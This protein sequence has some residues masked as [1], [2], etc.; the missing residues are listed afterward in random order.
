MTDINQLIEADEENSKQ[1]QK[2]FNQFDPLLIT[3]FD[4]ASN[5]FNT[6]FRSFSHGARDDDTQGSISELAKKGGLTES[7]FKEVLDGNKP[8]KLAD[9]LFNEI[10]SN[11]NDFYSRRARALLLLHAY[12]SYMYAATDIRRLRVG[13][14]L[15]F[16]RLEIESIALMSLFQVNNEL[17]YRWV[18]L[19]GDQ[20]GKAFFNK[21][22]NN[23][24]EFSIQFDLTVEWNLAS[25]AAQHSR[26]IGLVDGLSISRTSQSD[27]YAD[28]F[29]VAFQDFDPEKPEQMIVRALY[30]LRTQVK[31]LIPFSWYFQRSQIR[32]F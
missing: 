5:L 14:A 24:S 10:I 19:K 15:G 13:T 3:S 4:D 22:K 27:R 25:S 16:M 20:Q 29:S 28:N 31:L 11:R 6:F 8:S 7:E 21:T 30:I 23:V 26:F 1:S 9:D 32:C 18:N 17:P 2:L 12:R